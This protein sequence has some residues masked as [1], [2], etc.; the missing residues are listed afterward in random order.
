MKLKFKRVKKFNWLAAGIASF[1][2]GLMYLSFYLFEGLYS[3]WAV[4]IML[5]Y[6][7]GAGLAWPKGVSK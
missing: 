1:T 6:A 3:W 7:V 4:P 5:T 2:I